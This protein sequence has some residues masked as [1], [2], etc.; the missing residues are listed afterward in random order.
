MW[1]L[2]AG[3]F[4]VIVA[5]P[6]PTIVTPPVVLTS[7]TVVS[8][9]SYVTTP[10]PLPPVASCVKGASPKDLPVWSAPALSAF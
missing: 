1:L 9:E 4:A 5:V 2:S 7:A 3:L 8:F 10:V 6:A